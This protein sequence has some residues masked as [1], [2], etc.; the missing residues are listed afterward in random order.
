MKPGV[1]FDVDGTL[2]DVRA[3]RHYVVPSLGSRHKD[4]DAFH[5]ESVNVLPHAHVA[6]AARLTHELGVAVLIVTARRARWRNH[7]AMWLALHDIPSTAMW[8]RADH[9][10][11]PDREVKADILARIRQSFDVIHAWDDN[12]RVIEVWQEHGI[13]TTIVP[14]WIE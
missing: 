10:N 1:I 9:D 12:P 8:M 6:R 11:R 7:T 3:I 4:F 13:P 5:R 14:G 2:A